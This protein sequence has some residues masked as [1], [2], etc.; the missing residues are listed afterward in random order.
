MICTYCKKEGH[1]EERCFKKM[2]DN[3]ITPN[4]PTST[5]SA[6]AAVALLCYD[7]CLLTTE[8]DNVNMNTFIADSGAS[9]HMVQNHF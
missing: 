2:R 8:N 3:G 5:A 4:Y 7:T 9:A 6:A 1:T